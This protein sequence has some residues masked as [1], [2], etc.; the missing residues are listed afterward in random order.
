[1]SADA[2]PVEPVLRVDADRCRGHGLCYS[3]YPDLVDEDGR[4]HATPRPLAPAART[5]G[6]LQDAGDAVENCPER[7]LSING[8]A[9]RPQ[10]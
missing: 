3:A 4:G 8:F 2:L 6:A 7:A 5:A 1:M 9:H 10:I